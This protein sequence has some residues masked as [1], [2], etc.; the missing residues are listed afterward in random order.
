MQTTEVTQGQWKAVMG[1]N[2]SYFK[3]CGE[4]CPVEQVSWYDSQE[5]IKKINQMGE[6]Y[7]RLPTEAEWEYA[8][9]AGTRTPFAFGNCLNTDKA[10]YDGNYPLTGCSKGKYREKTIPVASLGKNVWGLYD[11]HGNV[12][13]WCN[14]WYGDY[15]DISVTDPGGP[16]SGSN[17]VLRGGSWDNNAQY[18]RSAKR[19]Y[20]SPG[21]RYNDIG[22]RL[23]RTPKP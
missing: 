1:N 7:Y 14:N 15:P 12:W 9:R 10:N 8:A 11:M 2:P 13:E 4:N 23:S 16:S 21:Y 22:L 5:F 18:C 3:A 19:D 20:Y 6:G 17:R